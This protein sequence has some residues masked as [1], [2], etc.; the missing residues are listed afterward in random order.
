[1]GNPRGFV[2]WERVSAQRRDRRQRVRDYREFYLPLAEEEV[3]RQGGRCMDCGVPFCQQGCPLGNMIPDWNDL[4]YRGQW[5][6]AYRRLAATNNF[7]EFTGRLC[8]APCEPA[9]VLA[10]NQAP[11]AI[12]Q[13]E[14]EIIE[15]AFAAGWVRPEPPRQRTPFKVAV[16]GS[17]P[18]GLAAAQQLNRV[19]H[20]VT[21]FERDEAPGGLLR[22]GIPDFKLEKGVV[23]RRLELLAAEGVEF[24]TGVCVGSSPT[25]EELRNQHDALLLAI[26]AQRPRDLD[27]PGRELGGVHFA[28]E[29]LAQQNRMVAGKTVP[30][31]AR[32]DAGGKHVVILGGGDT[33][34]DCYGTAIRQGARQV[35]Q[36]QIWP[37]PPLVRAA[38]NPW[39]QWP[40]VFRTSSSQEEG[41]ERDFAVLTERLRGEGG[42]ISALEAV[43]IAP[44]QPGEKRLQ[45]IVGSEFSIPCDLLILAIGFVGAESDGLATI[46]VE[47]DESGEITVDERYATS[48]PGI[49][50]AGD[51]MRG[52]S[53]IVWAIMDGREAARELDR[54]LRGGTS[55]LPTRGDDSYFGG[56][57]HKRQGSENR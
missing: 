48:K 17:G 18:A 29:Y 5:E 35:L 40:I 21:V 32:I 55:L 46:G 9:C 57:T 20:R 39:P 42:R 56:P 44:P 31:A 33:G 14:K 4:V 51:A 37:A 36:V 7:P 49:Y 6:A 26:G 16:V 41:G 12:E 24:V 2:E 28:M 19:G 52:A 25:W 15:H 53:L 22:Y 3:R 38:E 50:A 13:I 45:R 10:I 54:Y 30:V 43:R 23:T 47:C 1:M 11:V 27:L 8:P 34:S